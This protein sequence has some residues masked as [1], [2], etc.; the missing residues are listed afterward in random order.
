MYLANFQPIIQHRPTSSSDDPT[1]DNLEISMDGRV[2]IDDE[3]RIVELLAKGEG[4]V[5]CLQIR[6]IPEVSPAD[7]DPSIV[8]NQVIACQSIT[9][10]L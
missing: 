3:R 7:F 6:K 4:F 5:E 1:R 9:R 2:I 10:I 8:V